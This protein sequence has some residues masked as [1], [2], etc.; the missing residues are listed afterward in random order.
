MARDR[1][2]RVRFEALGHLRAFLTIFVGRDNSVYIHPS[3]PTGQPWTAPGITPQAE[4]LRL[5]FA[6]PNYQTFA[7]HKL[8][9]H[10]SGFIHLT[11]SASQ[12]YRSGIRGPK[13][14]EITLPYDVAVFVPCDPTNLPAP[15]NRR[16][17]Y[18]DIALPEN[19]KP[20]YLAFS[21]ISDQDPPAAVQGPYIPHPMNFFFPGLPIGLALTMWPVR[22]EAGDPAPAWPPFPFFMFRTAA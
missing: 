21:L 8:S 16:G 2:L 6:S 15:S 20:F 5:G 13:F 18:V 9:F 7:L 10:P 22:T 4:G 11:D 12:R 17:F 1:P 14:E 19:V 3:R